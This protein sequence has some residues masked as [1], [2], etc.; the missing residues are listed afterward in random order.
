M[1]KESFGATHLAGV[2][3]A[4]LPKQGMNTQKIV[5]L[6][7]PKTQKYAKIDSQLARK[8]GKNL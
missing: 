6:S 7:I 8:N 3:R 2:E 1:I 4:F 5:V